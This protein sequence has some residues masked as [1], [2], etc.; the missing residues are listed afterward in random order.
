MFSC[1][2]SKI[3]K[4]TFFTEQFRATAS[5][6]NFSEA[7]TKRFYEKVV[8]ENLAKFTEKHLRFAKFS[9]TPF[10]QNTYTTATLLKLGTGNSVRKTLD[11]YS[12]SKNFNLKSTVEVYHRQ[13]KPLMYIFVGL[14]CL[15]PEAATR[16]EMFCKNFVNFI[17]KHPCWSLFLIKLQA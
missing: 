3:S 6:F 10:L 11:E 12:L 8:L 7:T 4:K 9:R 15:L 16:G 2:F 5:A 1:E 14:G 17:G 13:H